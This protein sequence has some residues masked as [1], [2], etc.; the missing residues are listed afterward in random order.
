MSYSHCWWGRSFIR[1]WRVIRLW[2]GWVTCHRCCSVYI[3]NFYRRT[4]ADWIMHDVSPWILFTTP[5]LASLQTPPWGQRKL[6][7][8]C[9]TLDLYLIDFQMGR[10]KLRGKTGSSATDWQEHE[11][12]VTGRSFQSVTN[13][14]SDSGLFILPPFKVE[15]RYWTHWSG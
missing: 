13:T 5:H 4:S 1:C 9:E 6:P 14:N 3:H 2:T 15:G 10:K 8:H 11:D 12:A 7:E